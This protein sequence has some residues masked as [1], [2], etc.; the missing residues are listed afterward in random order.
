M[1]LR[2]FL[3]FFLHLGVLGLVILGI[4]DSSFLFFPIGNDLLLVI[5]AARHHA[6][7]PVY[8][9]AASAGSAGGVFLLDLVCRKG[10]QEGL[11]RMMSQKRYRNLKHQMERRIAIP[12]IV[13]CIAPP[14][15]P[16]TAVVGAAS[17]FQYPRM[18]LL[19]II[20]GA[21]AIRFSLVGW[22][23]IHWGRRVLQVADSSAFT[24]FIAGF[25]VLCVAGST[26]SG[27]RWVRLSRSRQP[28]AVP[29]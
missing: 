28:S 8:V 11:Q 23:A 5:L 26:V 4:L 7:L 14:P 24:W 29:S 3:I 6:W 18:R 15:F 16:F 2:P 27:I 19:G 17:A 10:G 9:L 21:R 1:R 12:L 22:A 13:A 20:L 25:A